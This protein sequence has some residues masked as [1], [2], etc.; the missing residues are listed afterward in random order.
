M[1]V[2]MLTAPFADENFETVLDFAEE[3]AIP[4]LE[5][6]ASPNSK[7]INP[8]RL[9][10]KKV[11]Q[12]RGALEDRGLEITSLTHYCNT[13]EAKKTKQI[14]AHAKKTIDAA[15]ALNVD[16]VCM[17]A[18]MPVEGMTKIETIQKVL[19]KIFKP[20]LTYARKKKV[21]IALEN[22]FQMC[23]QGLDTFEC[24]YETIPD[25][26]FGLNYDPS[27]LYHQCIDHNLPVTM[28]KD[29]IFHT[30]AKD[31]LVIEAKRAHVGVYAGG[32]WRYVIPGFGNINWGEYISHLRQNGYD[33][34]LSIEHEDG[35]QTREDGFI[36]GAW[37]LEQFC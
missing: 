22:W 23:L 35:T 6:V 4:C 18:G 28:F 33:G 14:Q 31:T 21:N 9:T 11:T 32:W 10:P 5:V 1:K 34:V 19:P 26:N 24:L 29:R 15:R 30:H 16:T 8:A 27:H 7:H 37:F 12:I 13:T 25:A 2:G 17:L 20:I 36:R 3:A